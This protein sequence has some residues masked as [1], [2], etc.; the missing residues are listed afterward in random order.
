MTTEEETKVLPAY[1]NLDVPYYFHELYCNNCDHYG[2]I[3]RHDLTGKCL[4]YEKFME[5]SD[6]LKVVKGEKWNLENLL[7]I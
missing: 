3:T 7:E 4:R 2:K 6:N 5:Q 1:C